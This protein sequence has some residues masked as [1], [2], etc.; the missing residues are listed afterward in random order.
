[1]VTTAEGRVTLGA[2]GWE[3]ISVSAA[4]ANRPRDIPGSDDTFTVRRS[5]NQKEL[6]R[7]MPVLGSAGASDDVRQAAVWI[8][9]DNADYG[10]LGILVSGFGGFGPR[11]ID[12]QDSARAMM[13]CEQAGIDIT[14]RAIWRDRISILNALPQG[15]VRTWLQRKK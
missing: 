2:D 8:V 9:T 12:E 7:L 13:I 15:D 3:T 4:C 1:M 10:D 14:K 11:V 5:P 6:A